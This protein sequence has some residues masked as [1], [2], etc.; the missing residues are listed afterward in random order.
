M[1]KITPK[2]KREAGVV[3][4]D[5]AGKSC[6]LWKDDLW[7]KIDG[8]SQNAFS[9][10]DG[11]YRSELRGTVVIPVEVEIKWTKKK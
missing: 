8:E 6:F 10:S 7:L 9:L 11:S 3:F 1:P 4:E 2:L 5:L